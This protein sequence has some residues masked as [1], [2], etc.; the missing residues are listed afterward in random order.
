MKITI[1]TGAFLTGLMIASSA[2]AEPAKKRPLRRAERAELRSAAKKRIE[3][4]VTVY[5]RQ[6][7]PQ[8]VTELRRVQPRFSVGT[9]QYGWDRRSLD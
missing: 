4:Q 9:T 6:M 1:W 2:G 8:V 7:R 5:G 3:I